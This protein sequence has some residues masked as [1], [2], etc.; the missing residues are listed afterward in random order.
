VRDNELSW[1]SASHRGISNH[2]FSRA[3][4]SGR[5]E[6]FFAVS[7]NQQSRLKYSQSLMSISLEL[8]ALAA[9]QWES[10]LCTCT[11]SSRAGRCG[12]HRTLT[13]ALPLPTRTDDAAAAKLRVPSINYTCTWALCT[14]SFCLPC[15]CGQ[16]RLPPHSLHRLG[17]CAVPLI[18]FFLPFWSTGV[19]RVPLPS[20]LAVIKSRS[21]I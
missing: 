20:S 19:W 9:C 18:C 5:P 12:C 7:T 6:V 21:F 13:P 2:I 17:R 10:S 8:V 1:V 3:S 11:C 15:Q 16:M 4:N 14:L